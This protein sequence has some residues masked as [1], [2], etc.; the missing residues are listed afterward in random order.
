MSPDYFRTMG[1][2]LLRGRTFT[3][4][5][6]KDAP[7]VV[8]ID[9]SFAK[10]YWPGEDAIGRHLTF[11]GHDSKSV[12][13]TV[14][15]IV[16]RVK[17]EGLDTDSN[18]VQAYQPLTQNTW[19]GMTFVLRTTAD[20]LGL[21]SAA[22]K[23]VLAV[24]PDEPMYNVRSIEQVWEESV[25][26]QRLNRLLFGLFAGLALLLSA[27]GIYGVM[28]YAVTQRTHE[29]GIRIALGAGAGQVVRLVVGHGMLLALT[30]IAI[31]LTAALALTRLMSTFLFGVRAF[32][33]LT[34]VVISFLL[35]TVGL[36][37]S[38]IPARKATKV[39]PIIALRYE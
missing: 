37:S 16:G 8:V 35:G 25:A 2:P 27:V 28:A 13:N 7:K 33:P 34:F 19:N 30:G 15:G 11:G 1:I 14:V 24:D 20:P 23:Q 10:Q 22:R 18:R 21:V 29:I 3:V 31:G 36:V 39:D 5:D 6:T 17:M 32:D 38:Y 26:P 4:Q 9:E 12:M